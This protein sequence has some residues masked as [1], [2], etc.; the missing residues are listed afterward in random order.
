MQYRINDMDCHRRT[1]FKTSISSSHSSSTGCY[2]SNR[3]A[4]QQ[5]KI[6]I[7]Q[8]DRRGARVYGPSRAKWEHHPHL[9]QPMYLI[10]AHRPSWEEQKI[11]Q[12]TRQLR[13][14]SSKPDVTKSEIA[15]RAERKPTWDAAPLWQ[16][17]RGF[18]TPSGR[19]SWRPSPR[20]TR[21]SIKG[22][23]N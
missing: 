15:R 9:K 5:Q 4:K 14:E 19:R 16:R 22:F 23:C 1:H 17:A 21:S 6:P 12:P 13:T 20:P 18:R 10:Q 3:I 2:Y 11:K 7:E 8:E